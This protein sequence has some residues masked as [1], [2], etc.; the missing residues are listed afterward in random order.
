M[1]KHLLPCLLI[2][3]LF[4][5]PI[6]HALPTINVYVN[7]ERVDFVDVSPYINEDNRTMV[8]IRFI[9]EAL[10]A[11]VSWDGT[12]KTVTI[13]KG[14]ITLKLPIGS[15]EITVNGLVYSVDTPAV[16]V[17]GRTMVPVRF[18]AE[19][20]GSDVQWD[21]AT[22][23]VLIDSSVPPL[24]DDFT[25]LI[26]LN[27]TDLESAY[28]DESGTY[29]G[30]G[31]SDLNEMLAAVSS[32]K[33]NVL[34]ETGGTSTWVNPSIDSTQN[35]R[36]SVQNNQL[37]LLENVGIS[38]MG[39]PETLSNFVNW[40]LKAY[41]AKNYGIV[42]WNHGGGP[43]TG[44]AVDELF[45]GDG[46]IL[47]ELEDA[48]S[49]VRSQSGVV[50]DFI[51]FDACLMATLEV[52]NTLS[53]Y[54]DYLVASQELEPGHGWDYT[55]LITS[56]AATSDYS[57]SAI[58]KSIAD[59]FFQQAVD[60]KTESDVTLS[61]IDL[62]RLDSIN[63][64]L[65]KFASD[66]SATLIEDAKLSS[67]AQS[68]SKTKK[69]GGN[70]SDQGYTDLVDLSLFASNLSTYSP[71]YALELSSAV[72]EA[73]VYQVSG[74]INDAAT[75]L[76]VYFPYL[77]QDNFTASLAVQAQ[78]D[79]PTSFISLASEFAG[80]LTGSAPLVE[81]MDE[82]VVYEPTEYSAYYE[83]VVSE[84]LLYDID[85][86][87]IGVYEYLN[88]D[89]P[90]YR[91][92][93]Y[94]ALTIFNEETS[95]YF[96]QFAGNWTLFDDHP[97]MMKISY[98]DYDHIEYEIPLL[99]N[100]ERVVLEAVWYYDDAFASGGYYDII[101]ARR[102]NDQVTN[103]PDR[104]IILLKAGDKVQPIYTSYLTETGLY[105]EELGQAFVY[106]DQSKLTYDVLQSTDY[107]FNFMIID[108]SGQVLET[109]FYEILY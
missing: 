16:L 81:R 37:T 59:G 15:K 62:K 44:Y 43:I 98:S 74:P 86:V 20:L 27:G 40:A 46:L 8:P 108:Y 67:I 54:A 99:L 42:L 12:T 36:W 45:S 92:L 49:A 75:G 25:L 39:D 76:S 56:L 107:L 57:G 24:V 78:L 104:N 55:S 10:G 65:S 91:N 50:F 73:V 94:D 87:Y 93:G 14:D 48:F 61:V 68:V 22:R 11:T 70:S 38:N 106:S 9:S 34:V 26:Y 96:E 35:Q 13:I 77:D 72:D 51:G 80:K 95:S 102:P 52:A 19:F 85:K 31:T 60:E 97:I 17:S 90:R 63:T 58:G 28:D 18:P 53:P 5:L 7:D 71:E 105:Q 21:G 4:S 32:D 69:Y 29:S 83:L 109:D 3:I 103:M 2:L 66:L 100:D 84:D 101:G 89:T 82:I 33:V 1:K 79:L 41:P 88:G 47:P 23:S 6:T 30:A 64:A